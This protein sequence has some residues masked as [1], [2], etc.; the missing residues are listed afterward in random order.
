MMGVRRRSTALTH[1]ICLLLPPAP[2]LQRPTPFFTDEYRCPVR[3]R[4][5]VRVVQTL[6]ARQAEL[7][8][9]YA[10][11]HPATTALLCGGVVMTLRCTLC[12]AASLLP[13]QPVPARCLR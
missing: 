7:Q 6:V 9:R 2:P 11:F 8:H 3:V 10:G 4:D 13:S 5:I 12:L 1:L